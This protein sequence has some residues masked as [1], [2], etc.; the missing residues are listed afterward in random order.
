[1][2][3]FTIPP[4][5]PF[6][7]ALAEGWLAEA[8]DDPWAVSAG[9]I[10]LPTRRAAR[11]LA[12]RFLSA[13][14]GRALL[15]PRIMAI[16]GMDEAPLALAD[17][18]AIPP[19]VP[20]EQRLAVLTRFILALD[21]AAGAPRTADGAWRLAA[22]LADLMDEAE[23]AE[24]ALH[25]QLA[26]LAG[27]EHAE[28]WNR[29]VQFLAIVTQH[30]P[31]WLAE[32]GLMNP[33]ARQ[34][35]LLEAQRTAWEATPPPHR[36]WLA[37]VTGAI[38]AVARLAGVVARLPGC[39]VV[40][41][42][43]DQ[44]LTEAQW[45]EM[46]ESHPQAGLQRLLAAIS[47]CRA[48]VAVWPHGRR[49]VPAG[50]AALLSRALLPAASLE[51]WQ[52]KMP[53]ALP[54]LW[55][56]KPTDQQDEALS[57]ALLLRQALEQPGST[58]ALVTPDRELA[59][60][61]SAELLRFGVIAD[62][63]AGEKLAQTPPALFLRLL[64][65]AVAADLAPVK[66]L[67]LLKHPFTAAG[68][69]TAAARAAA[70]VLDLRC[71]R[72][73]RP[74]AGLAGLRRA[75]EKAP[76]A[77]DL[78]L[79]L[80]AC[81]NPSLRLSRAA[82]AA[83][84]DLLAA[85]VQSA[86]ALATSDTVAGPAVLWSLD[87]GEALAEKLASLQAALAVLPDQKP[88][89]LPLLLE[90]M[91]QGQVRSRRALRG[92]TGAE[93]PRV[94]IWGRL[95]ARLQSADLLVLGSLVEGVWPPAT[96]P[97]PWLSRP[98]RRKIKLPSPEDRVGEA[99]HDFCA[100]V[101]AAPE[102]VL[103]CPGRRDNAPA[104]PS[105]WLVRLR[106]YLRGQNQSLKPHPA[107]IWAGLMDHPM[108]DPLPAAPPRPTP[109]VALRPRV[110]SVTEVE[111]WLRDPYAIYARHILRLKKLEPL[112]KLA[113]AADFGTVVHAGLH[114]FVNETG[115]NW[116]RDAAA[117]LRRS[118]ER[119]LLDAG[120]RPALVAWWTPRLARI[121]DWVAEQDGARYAQEPPIAIASEVGGTWDLDVPHGFQLTGRADRI[122]R[123]D[124]G[125]LVI[126]DYKTGVVPQDSTVAAG[127]APQLPLEAAMAAH[128]AFPGFTGAT[129]G[130][131]Y[132][133]LTG[134]FEPGEAHAL[135]RG[136]LAKLLPVIEQAEIKFRA[137]VACFDNPDQPY[138]SHPHPALAPRFS[139]YAQLAR[140]AEWVGVEDDP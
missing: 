101:C 83:P 82:V 94:F 51:C 133:H 28:H 21:G 50:R 10:L 100:A 139:D 3:L 130:L 91:I 26:D 111:T 35:A 45:Q 84:A 118:L 8:G 126:L 34:V 108:G 59:V 80:E 89:T 92:R 110:L 138:L 66:L 23:R 132:W 40:L 16:G 102:V 43:L 4:D 131:I 14:E 99:A 129:K 70:R 58:A 68:L 128:S 63:S 72:G 125:R 79:R 119:E 74:P 93:H 122:E 135:F 97:G 9:L 11:A 49:I 17:A 39:A 85:L 2:N 127:L 73:P 123:H 6:L 41:P 1:M 37:G 134:G 71:L 54:G 90:A 121:A 25:A 107:A 124:D 27:P 136:E 48:D 114:R 98:M 30:W 22:E 103:S 69:S 62:D 7:D 105:R 76:E 104:V 67:A 75:V 87:E 137:L 64:A 32:Q 20:A 52:Q 61:V 5:V 116:P 31:V 106:A 112:E 88:D 46:D 24:V 109:P 115:P 77:A 12:D 81:L 44:T 78:V 33:A 29:T 56:I 120:L 36:V 86:E 55:E 96:D 18:L 65:E 13:A 42:G 53:T 19:A 140:V 60:R 15:L 57:I 47:A 113:D 117:R 95:E 38:P